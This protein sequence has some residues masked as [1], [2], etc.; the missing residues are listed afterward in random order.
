MGNPGF[1]IALTKTLR[2]MVNQSIDRAARAR[3]AQRPRVEAVYET[4][5]FRIRIQGITFMLS[6]GEAQELSYELDSAIESLVRANEED[7]EP[8]LDERDPKTDP[9]E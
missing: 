1:D 5:G 4:Q 2:A 3:E 7:G 8:F 6:L 9:D